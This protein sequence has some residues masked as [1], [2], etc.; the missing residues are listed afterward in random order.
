MSVDYR[1]HYFY[2]CD[3]CETE[4]EEG[5]PLGDNA[6]PLGWT[7]SPEEY[8]YCFCQKCSA[9]LAELRVARPLKQKG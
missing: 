8:D 9:R 3:V 1:S 5:T 2:V 6:L 4:V 7:G